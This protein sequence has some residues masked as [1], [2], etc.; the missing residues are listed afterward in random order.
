MPSH[1]GLVYEGLWPISNVI[2]VQTRPRNQDFH[3]TIVALDASPECPAPHAFEF[4]IVSMFLLQSL[5]DVAHGLG[6]KPS[7]LETASHTP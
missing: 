6:V 1:R 2:R 5:C 4:G 3:S 7:I